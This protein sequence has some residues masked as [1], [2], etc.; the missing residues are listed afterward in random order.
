MKLFVSFSIQVMLTVTLS[1][2]VFAQ[3]KAKPRSQAPSNAEL[4]KLHSKAKKAPPSGASFRISIPDRRPDKFSFLLS[5]PTKRI[6]YH[7]YPLEQIKLMEAI[8]LEVKKFAY[9]DEA[10]GDKKPTITR[11][12][13]KNLPSFAVD[14]S[15]VGNKSQVFLTLANLSSK[16]TI[17]AGTIRRD[18]KEGKAMFLDLLARIEAAAAG[19]WDDR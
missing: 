15:K 14:V 5:D 8:M 6:V 18:E 19:N 4:Q 9:S 2:A 12:Y 11:F 16:V 10:V 13:D 1:S 17:D 3:Q 7:L